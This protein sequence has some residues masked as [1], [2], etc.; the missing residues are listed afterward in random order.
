MKNIFRLANQDSS[1]TVI[2][3]YLK[4]HETEADH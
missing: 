2:S 4:L 1:C 3:Y